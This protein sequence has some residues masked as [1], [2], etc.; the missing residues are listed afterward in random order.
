M[1][2]PPGRARQM[3]AGA[4]RARGDALLFLH[5]DTTLPEGAL[6]AVRR[7]LAGGAQAGIFRL[8]FDR[9][10]PLLHFYAWATR[11]RWRRFC[12]GDRGLFVRHGAFEAVGGYPDWPIF[13][14]LELADRLHERFGPDR[15]RYLPLAVTTAARRF[16]RA[17][18]LRQQFQN[19]RLWTRYLLGTDPEAVAHRYCYD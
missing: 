15:F 4:A 19:L 8:R 9:E 11:L 12:Y 17:G 1:A 3:N 18:P 13:E 14:D 7:A 10:T 16:E 6:A 2:A 5:A